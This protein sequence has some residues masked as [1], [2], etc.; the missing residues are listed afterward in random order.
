MAT[1]QL[2]VMYLGLRSD[3]TSYQR[4][5]VCY[6]YRCG[7]GSETAVVDPSDKVSACE[8]RAT[9]YLSTTM[10]E[11]TVMRMKSEVLE[12]KACAVNAFAHEWAHAIN[13]SEG[14]MAFTDTGHRRHPRPLASYVIG[15]IAQCLFLKEAY[16]QPK[17]DV[18]RCIEAAGYYT[19]E[20]PTSCQK[21]WGQKFVAPAPP[22]SPTAV[23]ARAS[24]SAP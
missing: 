12:E 8:E 18:A 6:K 2:A 16:A 19:F 15:S 14:L 20:A 11:A 21:G 17:F 10:R 13:D 23:M 22:Q 4:D 5:A 7:G 3:G 9:G 24:R 1:A